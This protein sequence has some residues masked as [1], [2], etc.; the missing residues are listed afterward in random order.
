MN[1]KVEVDTDTLRKLVIE[2]LKEVLTIPISTTEVS[3]KVMSK[4]N[5]RN[6]EWEEGLFKAVVEIK[7]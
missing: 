6:T 5:Y 4:Q 7:R 3:I 1:I 2:Y